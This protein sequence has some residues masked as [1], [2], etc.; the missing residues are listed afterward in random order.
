MRDDNSQLKVAIG[1]L[2][3]QVTNV[4]EKVEDNS[5]QIADFIKGS[6]NVFASKLTER[7]VYGM[8][9]LILTAFIG[10]L[11]SLAIGNNQMEAEHDQITELLNKID[12]ITIEQ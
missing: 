11:I 6:R 10:F 12:S 9:A 7:I 8:I 4:I 5:K 1:R 2:E 3:V